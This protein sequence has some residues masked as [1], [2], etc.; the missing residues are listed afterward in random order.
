MRVSEVIEKRLFVEYMKTVRNNWVF[1]NEV[2]MFCSLDDD[3]GAKEVHMEIPEFDRRLLWRPMR[4]G[5]VW[6]NKERMILKR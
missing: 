3:L 1:I 2:K 5:S 6:T 4:E